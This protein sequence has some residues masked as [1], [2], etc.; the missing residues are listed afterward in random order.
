MAAD[1]LTPF[2][3]PYLQMLG[4]LPPRPTGTPCPPGHDGGLCGCSEN[5]DGEDDSPAPGTC[6]KGVHCAC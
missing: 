4:D 1:S 3:L 5:G 6:C 2:H